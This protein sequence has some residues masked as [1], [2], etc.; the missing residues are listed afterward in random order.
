MKQLERE[1]R[2]LGEVG[3]E[4]WLAP[5]AASV[6]ALE[7]A[8]KA[9][10]LRPSRVPADLLRRAHA[11]LVSERSEADIADELFEMIR[12]EV[13]SAA[14]GG[15]PAPGAL[16]AARFGEVFAELD[17]KSGEWRVVTTATT[18]RR[19]LEPVGGVRAIGQALVARGYVTPDHQ[20]KA[21]RYVTVAGGRQRCLCIPLR[22]MREGIQPPEDS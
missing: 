17:R 10:D 4:E 20:G 1:H 2:D 9:M 8:L 12:T 5:L 15:G 18:I 6:A 22:V 11:A 14:T 13:L 3:A 16:T 19:I 21:T 7:F